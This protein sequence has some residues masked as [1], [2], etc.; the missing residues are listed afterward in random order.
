MSSK[1]L[2][3]LYRKSHCAPLEFSVD[4][5]QE[6]ERLQKIVYSSNFE[7]NYD[8]C[9]TTPDTTSSQSSELSSTSSVR[10][11]YATNVLLNKKIRREWESITLDDISPLM[12][13]CRN[14]FQSTA[15]FYAVFI[16]FIRYSKL[17]ANGECSLFIYAKSETV[18]QE[19]STTEAD[20]FRVQTYITDMFKVFD[21]ETDSRETV[22]YKTR[23]DWLD[24]LGGAYK[25]YFNPVL[26]KQ[27]GYYDLQFS[28]FLFN[29]IAIVFITCKFSSYCRSGYSSNQNGVLR[30]AEKF[31]VWSTRDTKLQTVPRIGSNC[32]ISSKSNRF[33]S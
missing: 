24:F 4:D 12:D 2:A 13:D 32:N 14:H 17:F 19:G 22:R 1:A 29:W 6:L 9:I 27:S 8:E 28:Y 33:M 16:N 7:N 11:I 31:C 3:L 20:A 23:N 21:V 15:N 5:Q 26:P 30:K 18:R 10:S 25:N